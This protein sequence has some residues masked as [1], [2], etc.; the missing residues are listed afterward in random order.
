MQAAFFVFAA[1]AAVAL[2]IYLYLQKS[3]E[4]RQ[5]VFLNPRE[6]LEVKL[7]EKQEV[8]PDTRRFRFALPTS[9]HVLGLPTGKHIILSATID[10][11]YVARPYTP[12]SSDA[13]LGYFDVMIKV[14]FKDV[15]PKFPAG[16]AMSQHLNSLKIGDSVSV[17]GPIGS[18]EYV[19]DGVFTIKKAP[20]I[21]ATKIGM[22]AGGTGIT[23]MLQ[24][25]RC[26]LRAHENIEISLLFA[27]QTEADI[28]MRAEL[29]AE[30]RT[31]KNLKVWY[32]LDRPTPE[33]AYS[34][35]FI[36]E[37]M[38]R[39][40]L[41]AAGP[42]TVILVCG[43]P[44]MVKFACMPNLLALHHPTDRILVW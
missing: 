7:V 40:H 36:D 10:G 43:P 38:C 32:T 19:Q 39:E 17:K 14:Y 11:A 30:A 28:L 31:H 9:E 18:V 13:N 8:S 20:S 22:I 15:H 5:A 44:P 27:N 2:G 16:G 41:P 42:D 3:T 29:E 12:I 21:K 1:G 35:G 6:R 34:S 25:L 24:V 26:V 23:P 4:K 33:W 37:A